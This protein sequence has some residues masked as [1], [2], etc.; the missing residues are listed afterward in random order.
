MSGGDTTG[1]LPTATGAQV[2]AALR[3]LGDQDVTAVHRTL[4]PHGAMAPGTAV[5]I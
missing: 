4:E 5:R 1:L 2:R 3:G